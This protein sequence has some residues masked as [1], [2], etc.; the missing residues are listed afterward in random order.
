MGNI[1][2]WWSRT[3]CRIDTVNLS[4][5]KSVRAGDVFA[6]EHGDLE[7]K[8]QTGWCHVGTNVH[9]AALAAGPVGCCTP[10]VYGCVESKWQDIMVSVL[11]M[12][13]VAWGFA[14][15]MEYWLNHTPP[16]ARINAL[17]FVLGSFF[18]VARQS[19]SDLS[20]CAKDMH[21][22]QVVVTRN[23]GLPPP[24]RV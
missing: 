19:S 24:Q 5:L 22:G 18:C 8:L 3:S 16:E 13:R 23:Q 11:V 2:L 9:E 6:V 15:F 1:L 17:L 20:F 4:W 7:L 12:E 14:Q 21:W 10:H